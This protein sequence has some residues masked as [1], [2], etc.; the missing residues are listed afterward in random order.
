M[1]IGIAFKICNMIENGYTYRIKEIREF[2][3]DLF[4]LN[5]EV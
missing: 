2:V 3:A 5:E 4:K 1:A